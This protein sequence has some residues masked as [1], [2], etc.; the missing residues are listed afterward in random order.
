MPSLQLGV[1][2]VAFILT[3][4]WILG[5]ISSLTFGGGIHVFLVAAIGMMMP[6]LLWGRKAVQ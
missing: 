5:S 2:T 6:R 3:V 1:P 4:L